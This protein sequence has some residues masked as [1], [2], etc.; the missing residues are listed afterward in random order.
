MSGFQLQ[1]L[2]MVMEPEP[3]NPV[4][5]EGVLNPATGRSFREHI[6]SMGNSAPADELFRRFMGRDPELDPLL[7]RAGLA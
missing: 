4:E 2:G 6:L 7:V 1:R 5:V 3:G